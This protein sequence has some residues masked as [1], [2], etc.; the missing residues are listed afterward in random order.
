MVKRLKCIRNDTNEISRVA[1]CQVATLE[2]C[3][4]DW[5]EPS[6]HTIV[7]CNFPKWVRRSPR[8]NTSAIQK[9]ADRTV[10]SHRPQISKVGIKSFSEDFNVLLP[11]SAWLEFP[12][13]SP[14]SP[15]NKSFHRRKSSTVLSF[16]INS[17]AVEC[18]RIRQSLIILK[19]WCSK[20][21]LLGD[22]SQNWWG[23]GG[24]GLFKGTGT[25][26]WW[27]R[28]HE[29]AERQVEHRQGCTSWLVLLWIFASVAIGMHWYGCWVLVPIQ[30]AKS[31]IPLKDMQTVLKDSLRKAAAVISYLL[32]QTST[33]TQSSHAS[34]GGQRS[35]NVQVHKQHTC[36]TCCF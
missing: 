20:V 26:L 15:T 23:V 22:S 5:K 27:R 30:G 32:S 28:K 1:V 7:G 31:L 16:L 25:S 13:L 12:L 34:L 18:N 35:Q 21:P 17:R 33:L 19:S 4:L 36:I 24:W 11:R 29:S 8:I 9:A 2:N 14:L 10:T 3:D 6:F